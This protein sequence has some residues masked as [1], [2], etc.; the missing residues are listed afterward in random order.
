MIKF[1]AFLFILLITTACGTRNNA[2]TAITRTPTAYPVSEAL[3]H[4]LDQALYRR[5]AIPQIGEAEIAAAIA[6]RTATPEGQVFH[7]R[8]PSG[9]PFTSEANLIADVQYFFS[10]LQAHYGAYIHFGGD[11]VFFPVRDAVIETI[12]NE[13]IQC[14]H[15]VVYLLFDGLSPFVQDLHF[16]IANNFF[17][18]NYIFF[19]SYRRFYRNENTFSCALSGLHIDSIRMVKQI[20]EYVNLQNVFKLS[21]DDNGE[22]FFYSLIIYKPE[23]A[24]RPTY[25][26]LV[27][28]YNDGTVQYLLLTPTR[29]NTLCF[30]HYINLSYM[31]DIPVLTMSMMGFYDSLDY[32][33]GGAEALQFLAYAE[34]LSG[35]PIVIVD[36]R[37]NL[38]GGSPP[39]P[40]MWLYSFFGVNVPRHYIRLASRVYQNYGS[41][42]YS[43]GT[44]FWET[45]DNYH[46]INNDPPHEFVY[47]DTLF[48][49]LIDRLVASSS[50]GFTARVL[51][52]EN[53]LIIGQNTMGAFLSGSYANRLFTP[54]T[55]IYFTIG[56]QFNIFPEGF[57][58][59]GWGFAPDIW[60]HG[61]ALT[62]ALGM[63]EHHLQ[64]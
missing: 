38:G 27:I 18:V 51:S 35:Q 1:V 21:M 57:F 15:T 63:I 56:S 58:R 13:N 14:K 44:P 11:A 19:T 10:F 33:D 39:L 25:V 28:S 29:G 40:R 31:Y 62:A 9:L 22:T 53:A 50:E 5:L 7:W 60:V 6:G 37:G 12:Q 32:R 41:P 34:S 3:S 49:L 47:N 55:G 8:A 52:L 36:L 26:Q 2:D 16:G 45:L 54:N 24:N 23:T 42:R 4:V 20:D 43:M 59:E 64:R 48:I 46:S 17:D 30:L 61:C